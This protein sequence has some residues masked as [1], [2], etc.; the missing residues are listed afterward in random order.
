ML[1]HSLS[2][3]GWLLTAEVEIVSA[4]N[5]LWHAAVPVCWHHPIVAPVAKVTQQ[6]PEMASFAAA[7]RND[8]LAARG[9]PPSNH[10][11]FGNFRIDSPANSSR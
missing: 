4:A 6:P 5:T 11:R 7:V 8:R 2:T 3:L 9:E 1:I 10:H